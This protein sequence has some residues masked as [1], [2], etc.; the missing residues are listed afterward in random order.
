MRTFRYNTTGTWVKG[1]THIHSTASDG[2]KTFEELTR[3]YAGA[4]YD[5]IFH[6]DHWV[7]SDVEKETD[8]S[9]LIRMDGIELDGKDHGGSQYHVVCLGTF[10]GLTPEMGFVAGLEAARAQGGFLILAH[11]HWMGNSMEDAL[12]WGFHGVEVYNHVCHWLNGKSDG[13]VYWNAMLQRFPNTLAF[14]VDDAHILPE[15]PGW[16]GG[17]I[18]VNTPERSRG[19]IQGA[20]RTGNF[21]STCGPEFHAIETDGTHVTVSVSPVRFVRLV[22][23]TY[24]GNRIGSFDGKLVTEAAFEIPSEWPFAYLEV[25]DAQGRLAWTN[26]LFVTD[27][28]E[29]RTGA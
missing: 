6:T 3:M 10:T 22:G 12:R 28:K 4:G 17:W 9:S 11:P 5:F 29:S 13:G 24:A 18:M 21:Y 8:E 2:G 25:E 19:A 26:P 23:P 7:A 20:I 1:N 15:H 16:N 14:A 27:G